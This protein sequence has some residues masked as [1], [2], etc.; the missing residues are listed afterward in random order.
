MATVAADAPPYT[1]TPEQLSTFHR[2]G[3]LVVEDWLSADD[4]RDMRHAVATMLASPELASHRS[5]FSTREGT[6][7]SRDA[8]FL[9]SGDKVRFFFEEQAFDAATGEP[10]RPLPECVNKIGHNLHELSPPFRRVSF[11]AKV[12]GA[13]RSLGY[14]RPLLPQS[15]YILKSARIG[16][17]V[18]PHVDGAFL[19]TAPQSVVGL[20]WPLEDC[21]TANGCLWAVPGSHAA[22]VRRRFKRTAAGDGTEFEPSDPVPFDLVGAVPLEMRAGSCV[23]LHAALTHYSEANT[24][25]RSRHAYSIHVIEGGRGVTYPADNWLQR[26]AGAPFP[27]LY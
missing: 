8:Y 12:C 17:A 2:D 10:V 22:G 26:E 23:L 5:I 24:S 20:W 27:A 25:E 16:G 11:D 15:M 9:G 19:Y 21:T 1:L 13:L 14:E 7:Q 3:Y 4:M 18:G 6:H